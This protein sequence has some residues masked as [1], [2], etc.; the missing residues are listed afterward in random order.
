MKIAQLHWPTHRGKSD[1][2]I[3]IIAIAPVFD[4]D[5]LKT[6]KPVKRPASDAPPLGLESQVPSGL[7]PTICQLTN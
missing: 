7:Y 5:N 1:S 3:R 6:K 4:G 2:I